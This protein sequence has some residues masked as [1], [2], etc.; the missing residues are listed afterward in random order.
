MLFR[1]KRK[2]PFAIRGTGRQLRQFIYSEDLAKLILLI[3]ELGDFKQNII[4]SINKEVI[5]GKIEE[6]ISKKFDYLEK[7][8]FNNKYFDVLCKKTADNS[9]LVN[10]INDFKFTEIEEGINKTID[11]FNNNYEYCRKKFSSFLTC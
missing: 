8:T 1:K 4:L 10:L 3:S 11:W 9:K 7:I 6:L 2:K 5:I